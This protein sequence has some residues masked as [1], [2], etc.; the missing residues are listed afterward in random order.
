MDHNCINKNPWKFHDSSLLYTIVSLIHPIIYFD[1]LPDQKSSRPNWFYI[2]FESFWYDYE[3][4]KVSCFYP[5]LRNTYTFTRP[6]IFFFCVIWP[7][8]TSW[9]S[10]RAIP[11]ISINQVWFAPILSSI[12]Q[13][14]IYLWRYMAIQRFFSIFFM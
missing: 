11:I 2:R 10:K 4:L 14:L 12:Y 3:S 8:M 5:N 6:P 9:T 1:D 7:K 13:S